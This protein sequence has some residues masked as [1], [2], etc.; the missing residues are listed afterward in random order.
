MRPIRTVIATLL[1]VSLAPLTHAWAP[2]QDAPRTS[3]EPMR[4]EQS[5]PPKETPQP[6][7]PTPPKTKPPQVENEPQGK[8]PAKQEHRQQNQPREPRPASKQ[9]AHARPAGKSAHIP[10]DQFKAHFGRPHTFPVR[11]V[12]TTTAVIPNQTRF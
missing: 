10:D 12:I 3:P 9:P 7:P 1:V 11:Q 6:T 5:K 8:Q 4:Q 2:E